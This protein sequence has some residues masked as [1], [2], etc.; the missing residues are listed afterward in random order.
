MDTEAQSRGVVFEQE[1]VFHAGGGGA[2]KSGAA[3][4]DII[5]KEICI[6]QSCELDSMG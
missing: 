4:C 1:F 2:M 5:G 6:W 3:M